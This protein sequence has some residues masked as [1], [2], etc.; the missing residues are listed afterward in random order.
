MLNFGEGFF[1][2]IY[3]IKPTMLWG[4]VLGC[5]NSGFWYGSVASNTYAKIIF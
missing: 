1:R 3:M 4:Y 2:K 5:L